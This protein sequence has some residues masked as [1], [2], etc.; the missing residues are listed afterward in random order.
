MLFGGF[1]QLKR[2]MDWLYT[3]LSRSAISDSLYQTLNKAVV[4]T[5]IMRHSGQVRFQKILL[6]LSRGV[7]NRGGLSMPLSLTLRGVFRGCSGHP[8]Q[9]SSYIYK[10]GQLRS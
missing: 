6:I 2:V 7:S 4:L 10:H 9:S 3:P 5:Q 8:L 1:G